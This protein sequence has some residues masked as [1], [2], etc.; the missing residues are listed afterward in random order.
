MH[1]ATMSS[2]GWLVIP[3]DLRDKYGLKPGM[4]V[5]VIDDDGSLALV[6]VADDPVAA[7]Q[8]MLKNGP[9]LTADLLE[10]HAQERAGEEGSSE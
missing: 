7:L 1:T 4:R 5:N 6:P 3:K 8:G 2:K 10:Q 9:S